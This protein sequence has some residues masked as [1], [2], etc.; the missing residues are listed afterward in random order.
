MGKQFCQTLVDYARDELKVKTA[1]QELEI[2]NPLNSGGGSFKLN[3][4]EQLEV[5][6]PVP[7][8]SVSLPQQPQI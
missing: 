2:Q 6:K 7:L 3:P 1:M 5:D 4:E 8:S